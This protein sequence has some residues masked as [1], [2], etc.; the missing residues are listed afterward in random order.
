MSNLESYYLMLFGTIG[1]MVTALWIG[2]EISDRREKRKKAGSA[3][4]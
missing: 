1:V 4:S 3:H 2:V